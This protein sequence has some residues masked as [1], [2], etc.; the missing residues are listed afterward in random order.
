MRK[1]NQ[2]KQI[3]IESHSTKYVTS[4]SLR[5]Q[6]KEKQRLGNCHRSEETKEVWK[7][8]ELCPGLDLG[9]EKGHFL[10]YSEI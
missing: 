5:Y 6:S 4:I 1:K 2:I 10:K 9:R 7:L 3:Q 8:C